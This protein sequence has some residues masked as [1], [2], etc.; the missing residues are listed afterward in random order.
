M[1]FTYIISIIMS[2]IILLNGPSQDI[3]DINRVKDLFDQQYS[4]YLKA[5]ES[6]REKLS[7]SSTAG[8]ET[9]KALQ[10]FI[11]LGPAVLPYLF[12]K[13]MGRRMTLPLYG[14]TMKRFEASELPGG[15]IGGSVDLP[16]LYKQWWI[17]GKGQTP[18]QFNQ[19]YLQWKDFKQQGKDNESKDK[20]E[21]IRSLGI[22]ALP[23]IMDKIQQG[24]N[25][26]ITIVSKLTDNKVD[27]NS[28]AGQCI[29]WWK[30]N[31]E[32]WLIPFPNKK[33]KAN[34]GQGKTVS[35]GQNVQLDGSGSTDEDKDTLNYQW[36]QI[37][38]PEVKLSDAN[39][40]KPSFT[41]PKVDKETEFVFE[42]KVN[43]GSR[44]KQVHPSC[45]SGQ[46]QPST[47]KIIIK[48]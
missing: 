5:G 18:Q 9:I 3:N 26:L 7:R 34:A 13:P 25:E 8:P 22:A 21:E 23:M 29:S 20:L 36:K 6:E 12:D 37:S 24:D 42:L 30:Q 14:L 41:A 27:P 48:P 40:V 1:S 4:L 44:I 28:N 2:S 17:N 45:E 35:S 38:G 46:S 32:D 16:N 15:K 43:D 10:G 39:A 11:K 47:V 33:P 19:R 31:K